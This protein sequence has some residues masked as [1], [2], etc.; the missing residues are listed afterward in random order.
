MRTSIICAIIFVSGLSL[1]QCEAQGTLYVSNLG[2]PS[3]GATPIASDS[4]IAQTFIVGTNAWGYRLDSVQLLMNT[5]S[6]N[7]SGFRVAIYR[8]SAS[9]SLRPGSLLAELAGPSPQDSGVYSYSVN[10]LYLERGTYFVVASAATQ[11]TS[12]HYQWS[13]KQFGDTLGS[14]QWTIFPS[15]CTSADGIIWDVSREF[16]HQMAIYATPIPEPSA[17]L[18]LLL[19]L[20]IGELFCLCRRR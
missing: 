7:A 14:E 13:Q 5:A 20:S 9:S 18:L 15:F 4:Y 2:Q 16:T 19:G 12:G 10:D 8:S 6:P 3:T 11:M 1:Y 17:S